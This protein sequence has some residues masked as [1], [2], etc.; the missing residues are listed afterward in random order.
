MLESSGFQTLKN[1]KMSSK[2]NRDVLLFLLK[3]DTQANPWFFS[4]SAPA[5]TITSKNS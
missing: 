2:C 5:L 3:A 1:S 4:D